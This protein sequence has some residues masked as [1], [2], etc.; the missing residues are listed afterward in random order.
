MAAVRRAA[1][2]EEAAEVEVLHANLEKM[3]SLSKKIQ[4][5][6]S[7][8]EVS[9]RTVKRLSDQSTATRSDYKS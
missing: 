5:S 2:A 9:G 3:K 7:R 1:F 8:L 6:M 4:G